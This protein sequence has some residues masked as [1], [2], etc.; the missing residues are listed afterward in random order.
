MA[1]QEKRYYYKS[2][3]G[4]G[5]LSLKS[6]LSKEEAKKYDVLT[7]S[8]WNAH[9]AEIAPK[10]LTAAQKAKQ[11]KLAE[12]ARLKGE[13]AKTDYCV[14]KIAEGVATPEEYAEVLTNRAA[15]RAQ[16]NALEE[17]VK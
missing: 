10:P 14:I 6:P 3:E 9:L 7:E 5:Y 13:L 2:K 8:Q 15:W 16:I 12:I 11:E 1:N 4:N 17:E